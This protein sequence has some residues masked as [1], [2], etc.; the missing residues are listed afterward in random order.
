MHAF[1]IVGNNNEGL[2]ETVSALAKKLNAKVLEYPLSKIEDV[3][4]LGSLVRLS[5]DEP[6]LIV[7]KNIHEATEEALNAFLKNLEEPQDNVYFVLTA[8]SSRKVLS[9]IVSRCQII[10]TLNGDG[11]GVTDEEE[12]EK[13]LKM[14]VG[15]KLAYIDKI[16][17]RQK[18]IELA[19]NTVFLLHRK[20]HSDQVKYSIVAKNI[21][22]VTQTL[23]RLK[24]NGNVNLQLANL[25]INLE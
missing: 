20:L 8:P 9:T 12:I 1:L 7:S 23:T 25:S 24:A 21:E 4:N 16:R 17:D 15:K 6:T 14:S 10:K 19:E 5:I 13:Y 18:A 22:T 2:D 11:G 3:R